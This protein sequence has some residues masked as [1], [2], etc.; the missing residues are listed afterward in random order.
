MFWGL[1][2]SKSQV[3]ALLEQLSRQWASEFEALS[4]LLANSAVVH[5]DETSWS[6]NNVWALLSERA[7][8]LVFGCRKDAAPLLPKSLFEGV[9]VSD[10]AAV[11]QGFS[12]AQK[13]WAHLLR[14]AIRL[15][16]LEPSILPAAI[17]D[18]FGFAGFKRQHH[19]MRC[20]GHYIPPAVASEMI[21]T[22]RPR[23][24]KRINIDRVR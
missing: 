18:T 4:Q 2:L 8:V 9:L 22:L 16:L 15:T 24:A 20:R 23:E 7:R 3:E 5:A 11:Y 1:N 17:N 12:Q 19:L 6:M 10:D 14:K 13:C 21:R